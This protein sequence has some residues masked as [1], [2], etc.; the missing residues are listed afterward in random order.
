MCRRWRRG[1]QSTVPETREYVEETT[2]L[3][4]CH[5]RTPRSGRIATMKASDDVHTP[6][7]VTVPAA[8]MTWSFARSGGAGGQHVNTTSSKATLIVDSSLVE[9]GP[10]ALRRI[11]AAHPST[12]RITRQTSKSQL[13]NRRLC[14]SQLIL[15]LDEAAKPPAPPRRKSKP[16]RGA[17]ERRLANKKKDSEKK[18]SRRSTDW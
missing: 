10:S 9:A 17:I 11:L 13:K 14:L 12:I 16:T 4:P 2:G 6:G 7:G 8:A 1:R 5:H 15:L 18:A 3:A